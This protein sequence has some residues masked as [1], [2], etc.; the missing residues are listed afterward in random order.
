[1]VEVVG[2]AG[3]EEAHDVLAPAEGADREAAADDLAHRREVGADAEDLLVAT[4]GEPEGDY[5]VAD[6]KRPI[7]VGQAPRRRE[8][9]GCPGQGARSGYGLENYG[10]DALA[11]LL[12]RGLEPRDVVVVDQ[13]HQLADRFRCGRSA[14]AR[15]VLACDRHLLPHAVVAAFGLDDLLAACEGAGC[16]H[17]HHHGLGSRVGEADLLHRRYPVDYALCELGLRFGRS[18]EDGPEGRLAAHRLVYGRQRVAVDRGCVI[19]MQVDELVAVYVPDA[20]A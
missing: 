17:G 11:F 16:A 3:V 13:E 7:L 19:V 4:F 2:A 15:G 12:H 8:V 5:L 6:E 9:L 10:G 20:A 14:S 18:G 1:V